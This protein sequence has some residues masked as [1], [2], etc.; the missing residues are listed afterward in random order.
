MSV[1]SIALRCENCVL[2]NIVGVKTLV[3]NSGTDLISVFEMLS[4][5]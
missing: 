5:K 1:E 3:T 2:T 4:Y